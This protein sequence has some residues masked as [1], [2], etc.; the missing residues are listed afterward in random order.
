VVCSTVA[1]GTYSDHMGRMIRP[2]IRE[3]DDVM[4]FEKRT[5]SRHEWGSSPACLAHPIGTCKGV[6]PAQ[7][8]NEPAFELR[9]QTLDQIITA[10]EA[11]AAEEAKAAR[12]KKA[13]EEAVLAATHRRRW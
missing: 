2:A 3:S 10:E 13:G 11:A 6:A 12:E 9:R 4:H 7:V 8:A 1:V 5:G